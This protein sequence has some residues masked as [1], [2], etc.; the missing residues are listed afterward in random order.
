MSNGDHNAAGMV[1]HNRLTSAAIET[2]RNGGPGGTVPAATPST[3]PRGPSRFSRLF[4]HP[5]L[6]LGVCLIGLILALLVP[7]RLLGQDHSSLLSNMFEG[8]S[9]EVQV[10]GWV[11]KVMT[12]SFRLALA[13]LLATL[14]AFRPRRALPISH[15]DP[16]VT[17]THILL[18]VVA[19]ALM[20]IVADNA[21]R[22]FGIFAAA[23]LVRFRTNIRDPKE[24]TVLLINLGIGLAAGVGHWDLAIGLSLFVFLLLQLLEHFESE[25]ALRAME[26]RVKTHHVDAT[27][28]ALREMFERNHLKVEVRT[29]NLED[30]K[31]PLGKIVYRIDVSPAFSTDQWAEEI[32]ASDPLNIDSIE[33]HQKKMSSYVYR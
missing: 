30:P 10:V 17:Q 23:S 21:V 27:D 15:R 26:L 5:A 2:R 31:H 28:Q 9:E 20:M 14:L 24:I 19:A 3:R 4:H 7:S 12:M 32:L 16:Y 1:R 11:Q 33:W 22:A 18:A 8:K 6:R 13:A 25:Q 29:L